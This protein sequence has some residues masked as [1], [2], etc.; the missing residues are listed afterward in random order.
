MR[1]AG[2]HVAV[3]T[4]V[5]ASLEGLKSALSGL[6]D[7]PL[8]HGTCSNKELV[9]KIIDEQTYMQGTL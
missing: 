1:G 5:E 4:N 9:Y 8:H 6:L 2:I 3:T 7:P